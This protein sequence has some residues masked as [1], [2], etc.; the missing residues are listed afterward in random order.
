MKNEIKYIDDNKITVIDEPDDNLNDDL[1]DEIDFS[2]LK[3]IANP[4]KNKSLKFSLEPDI[5][6]HF[7]NSKQLNQFLRLQI[8]SLEKIIV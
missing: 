6:Q 4:L 8:K 2:K 7:K 3:R 5:A 1:P